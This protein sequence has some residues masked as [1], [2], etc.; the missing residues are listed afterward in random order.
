[1]RCIKQLVFLSSLS[2]VTVS[3]VSLPNAPGVLVLPGS[4]KSFEQFRADDFNCRQYAYGQVG[5]EIP[6]QVATANT[7]ATAAA[8]SAVGAVTGA[9]IAGGPGAAMG[10]G[11]GLAVGGAAGYASAGSGYYETQQRYDWAYIQCMY[12]QGHRV[13]ISGQITNEPK[14]PAVNSQIPPPPPGNP[15]P[16]PLR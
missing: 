13:P 16:P 10:A 15:P 6:S 7:V 5:G 3:C 2:A 1:M 8:G 14:T 12:A 4:N 11:S 9:A